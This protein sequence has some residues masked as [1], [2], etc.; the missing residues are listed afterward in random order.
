MNKK[1]TQHHVNRRQFLGSANCAALG[2]LGFYNAIL[3]LKM[4]GNVAAQTNGNSGD[5]KALVCLF[6]Q[7][8]NDSYNML[9]PTNSDEMSNYQAIRSNLAIA[10]SGNNGVLPI[11]RLDSP[12]TTD[13]NGRSFGLH[14]SMPGMQSLFNQGDLAFVANVGT[15]VEPTTV[16]EYKAGSVTLPRGLFA[17]NAQA[18][19]WQTSIPQATGDVTGWLGRVADI[20]NVPSLGYNSSEISMNISLSGNNTMQIGENSFSYSIT[21]N[22]SIGL[23]NFKDTQPDDDRVAKTKSLMEEQYKNLYVEAFAK[24]SSNSFDNHETFSAAFNSVTVTT[25][26]PNTQLGQ[27]LKGVAQT[28]ASNMLLGH[29]RQTY[30]VQRGG[31]DNHS[32][33]LNTHSMLLEDIDEAVTA[34]WTALGEFGLQDKVMLFSASDFSRTLRSNGLGTDHA[35][36]GNHFILG[37][38]V[39]GQK[40]YGK[41]PD[42]NEFTLNAG[43]DVGSNGRLLPSIS[44]DEYYAEMALW[45]GISSSDMSVVFPNINN[46]WDGTSVPVGYTL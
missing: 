16:A 32:E 22:G 24:S 28:I 3:N 12:K 46:F 10:S 4:M 19:E 36:G 33:L 21:E 35:W 37:G 7:G 15:L 34:F 1:N 27:D 39:D 5:Y 6:L 41:Y 31:F 14:P 13:N 38:G 29:K 2:S 25:V 9:I 44:T 30:F 23:Y 43:L 26:F 20:I 11:N 42:P 40:I 18:M 8:G 17:H 45:F